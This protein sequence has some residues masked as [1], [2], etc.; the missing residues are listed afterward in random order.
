M[1]ILIL[2]LL[3]HDARSWWYHAKLRAQSRIPEARI[4]ERETIRHSI[5]VLRLKPEEHF[6]RSRYVGF[7]PGQIPN[8]Q[9]A[10]VS[11][12]HPG[13]WAA[14]HLVHGWM[15]CFEPVPTLKGGPARV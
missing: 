7:A 12:V 10:C 13:E 11:G 6:H 8:A 9:T 3:R 4:K 5:A 15:R 2:T 1:N 14:F